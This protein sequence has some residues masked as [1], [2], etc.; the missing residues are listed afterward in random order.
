LLILNRTI[1]EIGEL[2]WRE[3]AGILN[4]QRNLIELIQ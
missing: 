2:T 3:A 4:N 1:R